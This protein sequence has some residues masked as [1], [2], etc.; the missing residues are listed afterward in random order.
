MTILV[1]GA[2]GN[3]GRNVVD[4]LV[5]A[6]A[7]VRAL[8]RDPANAQFPEGVRVV[9]GDLAAPES[10]GGVFD[11]VDKVF[12]FPVPETARQ[13]VAAATAAGVRHVV[14]LSSAAVTA[15][16]DTHFHQPVEQAVEESGMAWT[17][18][19]PGEFAL[20]KLYLWGPMVRAE[21]VVRD[22]FP[23]ALEIPTHEADIADVAAIALL[24]AGHEGKAY[25]LVGPAAISH[26]RQA[27]AISE[28]L[29][30]EVRFELVTADEA[31]E[32]YRK[33][34]GWA[35]ANADFLLGF[36]DYS[37]TEAE[38]E[39]EQRWEAAEIPELPTGEDVTGKPAR[40]FAEWA[41]DHAEDFR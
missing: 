33:Q 14:V 16:Y 31:R 21:S 29:G 27:E 40:T 13:V 1:T 35:E 3:V 23:E 10:L 26:R 2:T 25:S 8:T 17:H 24:G 11:D 20:N 19:R 9:A 15:G 22:P 28:A 18:V 4:R 7:D 12:L 36:E 32:F 37:G 41:V 34:G 38:P 5:A 30:R 6:G 39:G